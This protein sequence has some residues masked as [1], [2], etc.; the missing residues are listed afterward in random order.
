MPNDATTKSEFHDVY[1]I[2]DV[3]WRPF[4][5]Q[6]SLDFDYARLAQHSYD[7]MQQA[8]RQNR[9]LHT[10]DKIGRQVNLIHG[11]EIR[12]R[13]ILKIGPQG[14]YDENEDQAC[15]QHTG[16][17]MSQM[18]LHGGYDI[19]SEAFKWGTLVQGSNL[20]ETWKDL[21]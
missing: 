5:E 3:A 15:N 13:H 19:F 20:I 17:L 6:A 11:Y 9:L 8:N 1:E 10:I 7:E 2:N 4:N 21:R 14:N 12:N 16:V 18:A